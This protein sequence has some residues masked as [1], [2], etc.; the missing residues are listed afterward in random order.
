M[1]IEIVG[2]YDKTGYV[3]TTFNKEPLKTWGLLLCS[4]HVPMNS[5]SFSLVWLKVAFLSIPFSIFCLQ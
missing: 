2:F 1:Y 5:S 3:Q 4:T